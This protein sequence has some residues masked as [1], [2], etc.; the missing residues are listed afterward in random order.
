M[1]MRNPYGQCDNVPSQFFAGWIPRESMPI[2]CAGEKNF[3][4]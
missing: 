1:G 4:R 3:A 2:P